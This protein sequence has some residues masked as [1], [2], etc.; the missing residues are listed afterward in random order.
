MYLNELNKKDEQL[1]NTVEPRHRMYL[2]R[3]Q[4][5]RI[6]NK[7]AVEPRHRMYLNVACLACTFS[8]VLCRTKT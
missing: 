7:A 6:L 4:A 1:N 5:Y 3:V 8:I 2:N